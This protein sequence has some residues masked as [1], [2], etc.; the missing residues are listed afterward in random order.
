MDISTEKYTN[1]FLM[2]KLLE[3]NR[4]IKYEYMVADRKDVPIGHIAVADGKISYDSK[5]EVMRTF[6]GT[7]EK[8]DL[9]N[10][11]CTDYRIIPYMCLTVGTDVVKWPLGKFIINTS[12]RGT[13]FRNIIN[14]NGYDLAKIAVDD[15]TTS[16]FYVPAGGV[17]TSYIAQILGECYDLLD[18]PTSVITKSCDQEWGIGTSKIKIANTLLGAINYTPIHF[19]ES[20]IGISRKYEFPQLRNIDRI[21]MTNKKSI[22]L[23][24]VSV[25]SDAFNI[26]NKF[27]R[28]TENAD[29][30][31]MIATYVNNDENDP[32]SVINRGRIIVDSAAVDDIASHE[33]LQ[34]YVKMVAVNSMQSSRTL[35]FKTLNMPG[36]GYQ[37]CL[38]INCE[39]YDIKGHFIET[40]WEM[41]LRPGGEMT[42]KCERVM[43]L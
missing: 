16:R 11:G 1:D 37:N 34:N 36:H 9:M 41:D 14:I 7:V 28:Y 18:I 32:Y 4:T 43:V 29:S 25:E 20:G 17:Y 35:T 30:A 26:P 40:A 21:Y 23:D 6:S 38:F 5:A 31:Y 42:H 8:S 24:G 13:S 2:E 10:I 3:E 27:V 22:I 19:D 12:L 33:D 39:Q 15:K